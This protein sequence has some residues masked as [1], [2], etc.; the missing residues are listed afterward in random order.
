MGIL[1]PFSL[2]AQSLS[3]DC[4]APRSGDRLMKRQLTDV[5][6]PGNAGTGQVWDFSALNL[7]EVGYELKYSEHGTDTLVGTE[8]RTMYYYRTLGDTLFCVG[9]ENPT[10]LVSYQQPELQLT[11]PLMYGRIA[12]DYF[13]GTGNYCDRLHLRQCGK[14][15]V[16]ADAAGTLILP[17]GDT[18]RHVLRTYTHRRIHQRMTPHPVAAATPYYIYS[19]DTIDHLLAHDSIRIETETWR[20]YAEGYRYPVL[21]TIKSTLYQ[22]ESP[23]DYASTSFLYLPEEQYYELAHDAPN[24]ALRDQAAWSAPPAANDTGNGIVSSEHQGEIT[25]RLALGDDGNLY[26][27]YQLPTPTEVTFSLFDVQG[28]Q[29]TVVHRGKLPDGTYRETIPMRAYPK[30]EYL[31]RINLSS[32]AYVEKILKR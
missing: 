23:H 32:N 3:F 30:G 25:Y 2:S 12:T 8:H 4:N 26:I 14:T 13:S 6:S 27:D 28:R 20:W 16:T 29:L 1:L 19:A 15:T 21:E 9:Y 5:C 18:L 7:P 31:I 11:F 24:Q 22:N 10:T 17:D